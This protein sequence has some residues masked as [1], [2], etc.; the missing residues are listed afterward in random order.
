MNKIFTTSNEHN[1][2]YIAHINKFWYAFAH[3]KG[4]NEHFTLAS[5]STKKAATNAC[6]AWAADFLK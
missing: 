4:E 6:F 2:F 3:H 1:D 5:F